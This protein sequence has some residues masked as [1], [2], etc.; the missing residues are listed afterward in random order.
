ML[1]NLN[2]NISDNSDKMILCRIVKE[3]EIYTDYP[4]YKSFC[5]NMELGF[6]NFLE[7]WFNASCHGLRQQLVRTNWPAYNNSHVKYTS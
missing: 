2:V 1:W 6:L 4:A 5:N 3:E 7:S